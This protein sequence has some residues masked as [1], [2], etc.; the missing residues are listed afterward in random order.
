MYYKKEILKKYEK[1]FLISLL[2][3]ML[4][5]RKY[6]DK[7]NE[8][9]KTTDDIVSIPLTSQGQE[10]VSVGVCSNLK[11][12][13]IILSTHRTDAHAI[14]KGIPLNSLC[15]ELYGKAAGVNKGKAGPLHLQCL[16]KG[17]FSAT[18]IVGDMLPISAGIG[19]AFKLKSLNKKLVCFFGDGAVTTGAFYEAVNL[20]TVWKIPLL[21]LYEN[22]RY[23]ECSSTVAEIGSDSIAKRIS[24]FDIDYVQADGMDV[25]DI[26]EKT[27][28]V[29]I[30]T[31]DLKRPFLL[32][33]MTY[34][35]CGHSGLDTSDG[36]GYRTKDEIREWKTKDPITRIRQSLIEAKI[37]SD[38][39]IIGIESSVEGMINKAIDFARNSKFPVINR[40]NFNSFI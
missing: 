29:L 9:A 36:T 24:G 40:E 7:V 18:G 8:L 13:D 21:L 27:R 25:I 3:K 6:Q 39:E 26:Y 15:A 34:R 14:A 33:C 28:K 32:E 4:L 22:N 2:K 19:L 17:F 10:A 30:E 16:E 23:A 5:I 11:D 35:Y 12:S 38:N 31:N 20:I 37:S 1:H